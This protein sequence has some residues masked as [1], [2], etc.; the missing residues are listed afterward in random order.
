MDDEDQRKRLLQ[1]LIVGNL[2]LTLTVVGWAVWAVADP[3]YW[4]PDA[5]ADQGR[6]GEEGPRGE[7]GTRG[8]VGSSGPS[9]PGVEDTQATADDAQTTAD[10]AL[11]RVEEAEGRLAELE[12]VDTS[13][14][15][16]RLSELESKVDDACST[17]SFELNTSGC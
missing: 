6:V 3:E 16:S 5:A 14:L 8:P 4:F 1:A 15:D 9:G 13:D 12:N 7:R 17:L 11:S 2:L 10:N